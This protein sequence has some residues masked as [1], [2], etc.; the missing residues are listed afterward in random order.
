MISYQLC[1]DGL[2]SRLNVGDDELAIGGVVFRSPEDLKAHMVEIKGEANDFGGLVCVYS[3]FTR[4]NQRIKGEERMAEVM[5]HNKY[6]ARIN[7]S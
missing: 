6:L 4:I 5:T 1:I 7:M 3:V 2:E